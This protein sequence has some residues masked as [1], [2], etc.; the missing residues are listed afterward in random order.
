[1]WDWRGDRHAGALL[2]P[3][4]VV[5]PLRTG[6]VARAKADDLRAIR[7]DGDGEFVAYLD[8]DDRS[9][10]DEARLSSQATITRPKRT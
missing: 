10:S 2:P 1:V 3:G 9:G 6:E 5:V 8:H 7:A 4:V